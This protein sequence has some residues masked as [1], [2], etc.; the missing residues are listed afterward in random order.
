MIVEPKQIEV[1][2]PLARVPEKHRIWGILS[3]IRFA[4]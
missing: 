1:N 2:L 3:A 4:T